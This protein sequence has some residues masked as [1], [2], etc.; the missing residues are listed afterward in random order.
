MYVCVCVCVDYRNLLGWQ[1]PKKKKRDKGHGKV[2]QTR[3]YYY[4]HQ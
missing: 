2:K 1:R 4:N 3:L